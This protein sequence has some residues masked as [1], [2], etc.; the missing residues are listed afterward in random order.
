MIGESYA[1]H[2]RNARDASKPRPYLT[3]PIRCVTQRKSRRNG[4]CSAA[5][6]ANHRTAIR[7]KRPTSFSAASRVRSKAASSGTT[8]SERSGS[9]GARVLTG[10]QAAAEF[11]VV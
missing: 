4:F 11:G 7:S 9:D 2:R 10:R 3:S 6:P 5:S 8:G 1:S